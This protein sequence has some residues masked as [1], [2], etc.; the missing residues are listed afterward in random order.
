MIQKVKGKK[1]L[2]NGGLGMIGS[3]IAKILVEAKAEVTIVD[4]MIEP[5]GANLFNIREIKDQ[6]KTRLLDI[7]DTEEM[8]KEIEGKDVIFN[9]AGQ[10][11]HNDSIVDPIYDAKLNYLY[12]LNVMECVRQVNPN[13]KIVFSGSR[14]QF[15]KIKN[16]PVDESH[17]SCPETPYALHK[18]ATEDMYQFYNRQY[19]IDTVVFRIANPYGPRGQIKHSKYTIINF[20]IRQA[21]EGKIISIF[22][23]GNQLRDYIFVEDLA[24]AFIACSL[25]TKSKGQI[26]NIGSGE[27]IPFIEMVNTIT[28]V[29]GSGS[30]QKIP[31]PK[32]YINVETGNYITN[33]T[34]AK[35]ILKWKPKIDFEEGIK[36]TVDYYSKHISKYL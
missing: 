11:A 19:D 6:V 22:G 16:I 33:I 31:W 9:L 8:K 26:F 36:I 7:K 32:D 18:Q 30:F 1:Y 25:S 35:N 15:G 4:A 5:F 28:K 14:L 24:N 29:V 3:T 34:K 17:A 2:I 10:V 12:Q 21:L 13:A 27:G 23:E 20:F